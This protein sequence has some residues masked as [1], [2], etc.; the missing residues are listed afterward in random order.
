[1]IKAWLNR[2]NVLMKEQRYQTAAEDYTVAI[3]FD[4]D[5]GAAYY[6]RAIA[7]YRLKKFTEA[8]HDLL[9]AEKLGIKI[10]G[11]TKNSICK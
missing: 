9:T 8:C 5:Y 11:S 1:M 7:F 10:I 2:G 6:N 4:R 3:S